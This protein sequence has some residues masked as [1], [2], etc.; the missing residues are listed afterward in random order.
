MVSRD[1]GFGDLPSLECNVENSLLTVAMRSAEYWMEHPPAGAEVHTE[2]A[3]LFSRIRPRDDIRVVVLTGASSGVFLRP[4]ATEAYMRAEKLRGQNAPERIWKI[5]SGIV[6]FL[7]AITA[8]EKPV[9]AR[10]NG[11]AL[12][13]GQSIMFACDII[14]AVEDAVICDNHIEHG[15][16]GIG[17]PYGL[18]PGDGGCALIPSF[19]SPALAKEYLMLARRFTARELAQL[20]AIN[21]AVKAEDLD[22]RVADL[23][24][25][26]L[27]RSA[28]A[29][30]WTKRVANRKFV[31]D[32]LSGLDAAAA[33]EIV[34]FQQAERLGWRSAKSLNE[35]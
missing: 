20:G 32:M 8:L 26:L 12:G 33:Y 16:S 24:S 9:I 6:R 17:S 4:Q 14:V 7:E 18:V 27:S 34:S 31:S 28:Y 19:L 15:E 22:E 5:F 10:V 25:R 29:L 13:F 30:A 11:D 3:E 21:Y 1:D 23:A 35:P 2:L